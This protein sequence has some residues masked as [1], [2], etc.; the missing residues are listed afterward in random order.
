M[1]DTVAVSNIQSL[2][3]TFGAKTPNGCITKSLGMDALTSTGGARSTC[4][5]MANASYAMQEDKHN[6][7]TK[8]ATLKCW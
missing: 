1:K 8:L 6:L 3:F 2:L 5:H 4:A 7:D